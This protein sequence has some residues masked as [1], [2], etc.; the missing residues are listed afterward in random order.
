MTIRSKKILPEVFLSESDTTRVVSQMVRDGSARKIGPRLYAS[1]M[2]EPV[3]V[4]IARNCWQIVGM[5]VP[6]GVI[7]FRTALESRPADDGSVFVTCGYKKIIELPGLRIVIISGAGPTDDDMPFIGGLYMASPARL[8]LENLAPT[9]SR[10]A[11]TRSMGQAVVEEKLAT[12]LRIKGENELNRIR[13]RARTIA[14]VVGLEKEFRLLDQLIGSLLQTQVADLLTPL[15]KS[16]TIGTPYDP[17]RLEQFETLRS[18]L[19]RSVLPTRIRSHAPGSAFYNE[20]FFDAYFSNFIEGTGFEVDEALGIVF[21]GI[22]G[23]PAW[24][25]CGG[26]FGRTVVTAQS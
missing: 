25:V 2:N 26:G 14:P 1:N 10:E 4:I 16:Y 6:G 18:A 24:P 9:K 15:A 7:G 5:L 19:A 3:E 17:L 8:L 23:H 21:S 11:A 12:I 13:D 22:T 20:S